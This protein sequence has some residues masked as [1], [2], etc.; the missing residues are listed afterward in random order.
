VALSD[1]DTKRIISAVADKTLGNTLAS[2]LNKSDAA[3]HFIAAA[4]VATNVSQ[5]IDFA[6]KLAVGD[7]VVMVPAVAGNADFI[8]PIATAGDLGQA[9]VVGNLYVVLRAVAATA[10]VNL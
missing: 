6:G 7:L 1:N 9:A 3:S 10:A 4:I 2:M 5:T 8:G